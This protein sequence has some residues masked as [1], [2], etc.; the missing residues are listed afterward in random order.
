MLP[1]MHV[2]SRC[3]Q[4]PAVDLCCSNNKNDQGKAYRGTSL[5][6]E[7]IPM[8][9]EQEGEYVS[10]KKVNDYLSGF[11]SVDPDGSANDPVNDD[12]LDEYL[13]ERAAHQ[14]RAASE[15]LRN[16]EQALKKS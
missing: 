4:S 10:E 16:L 5:S 3:L 13:L 8:V 2:S 7:M 11:K 12:A 1:D 15:R 14:L 6:R 9:R